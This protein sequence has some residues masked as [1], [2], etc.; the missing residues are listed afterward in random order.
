MKTAY[1]DVS[2]LRMYGEIHGE[3]QPIMFGLLGGCING[4]TPDDLPRSRLAILPGT[5]HTMVV[6]RAQL[7]LPILTSFLE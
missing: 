2:G 4:D 5:S 7:M 6:D 3:S 1:A